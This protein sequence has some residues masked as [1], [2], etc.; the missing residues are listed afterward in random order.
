MGVEEFYAPDR[1]PT[2]LELVEEAVALAKQVG[3]PLA[4][5]PEAARILDLA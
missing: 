1:S 4:D 3:R 2:N 5:T